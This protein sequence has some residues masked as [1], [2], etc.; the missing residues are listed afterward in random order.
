MWAKMNCD[1]LNPLIYIN[2]GEMQV[3]PFFQSVK[4]KGNQ[5]FH[6]LQ[7][8]KALNTLFMQFQDKDFYH[9]ALNT[10]CHSLLISN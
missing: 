9:F 8:L 5:S 3:W 10:L 7:A 2:I 4:I 1:I 6:L